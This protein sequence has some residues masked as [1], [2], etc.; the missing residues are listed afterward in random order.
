[1]DG[2]WKGEPEDDFQS[3]YGKLNY[4]RAQEL[5]PRDAD[6]EANLALPRARAEDQF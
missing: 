4:R 2:K 6:I 5:A 1:M 3:G